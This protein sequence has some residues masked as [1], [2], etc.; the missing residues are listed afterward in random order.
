MVASELQ[1]LAKRGGSQRGW[2]RWGLAIVAVA[3][4]AVAIGAVAQM[5]SSEQDLP[6]EALAWGKG[7]RLNAKEKAFVALATSTPQVDLHRSTQ[8]KDNEG[9][10]VSTTNR[11]NRC[12]ELAA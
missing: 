11:P 4:V 12:C 7:K 2:R 9:S 10:K 8:F 6:V 3:A 5:G 1:P